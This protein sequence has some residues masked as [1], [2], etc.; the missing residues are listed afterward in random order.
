MI[1]ALFLFS[2]DILSFFLIDDE[3]QRL[4]KEPLWLNDMIISIIKTISY[5]A[6]AVPIFYIFWPSIIKKG[7]LLTRDLHSTNKRTINGHTVP[8]G[9]VSG[10]IDYDNNY[11]PGNE[12]KSKKT[13]N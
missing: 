11:I 2:F 12:S 7:R 10:Y 3:T 13:R 4:I 5:I 8:S 1:F 6:W 9:L